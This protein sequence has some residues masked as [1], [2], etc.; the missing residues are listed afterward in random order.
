MAVALGF[1]LTRVIGF[2]AVL[3]TFSLQNEPK[4]CENYFQYMRHLL[5][6]CFI[7]SPNNK[8][9]MRNDAVSPELDGP[10]WIIQI[11]DEGEDRERD[12]YK[13]GIAWE[14]LLNSGYVSRNLME[15]QNNLTINMV[16]GNHSN[17]VLSIQV[18]PVLP[19]T[20]PGER[21]LSNTFQYKYTDIPVVF[22]VRAYDY[23]NIT[24]SLSNSVHQHIPILN[25]GNSC[26]GCVEMWSRLSKSS[27]DFE[28]NYDCLNAYW[29][30]KTE[31]EEN[32]SAGLQCHSL[33]NLLPTMAHRYS[34]CFAPPV[35]DY[36]T[37]STA[38]VIGQ[39]VTLICTATGK[40]TPDIHWYK[41]GQMLTTYSNYYHVPDVQEEHL[42]NYMCVAD[43]MVSRV[44]S[45]NPITISLYDNECALHAEKEM[46]FLTECSQVGEVSEQSGGLPG[47]IVVP[48]DTTV[49]TINIDNTM[50][51][52]PIEEY[53]YTDDGHL[54][55]DYE[56]ST[57]CN[58]DDGKLVSFQL[59]IID[60]TQ[61]YQFARLTSA[62]LNSAVLDSIPTTRSMVGN[63]DSIETTVS[64]ESTFTRFTSERSV[65]RT[66]MQG[67]R[68]SIHPIT[69]QLTL[70]EVHSSE[71]SGIDVESIVSVS[72]QLVTVLLQ[73]ASQHFTTESMETAINR[74]VSKHNVNSGTMAS[75]APEV[76][77]L[78]IP[79]SVI[80]SPEHVI[81]NPTS[82]P[83]ANS[84]NEDVDR[85][86]KKRD[87]DSYPPIPSYEFL[88]SEE[89]YN[90]YIP[91][92]CSSEKVSLRLESGLKIYKGNLLKI[93]LSRL[94][95]G[96]LYDNQCQSCISLEYRQ[97]KTSCNV[98]ENGDC[99]SGYFQWMNSLSRV[100]NHGCSGVTW[101]NDEYQVCHNVLPNASISSSLQ[102][103]ILQHEYT[104]LEC[105]ISGRPVPTIQ[106]FLGMQ[107]GSYHIRCSASNMF[108]TSWSDAVIVT[109]FTE[110]Y[111]PAE[112]FNGF[113]WPETIAGQ[114]A[115]SLERCPADKQ[116]RGQEMAS[117]KCAGNFTIGALWEEVDEQD[118]GKD[119]N[120]NLVLEQLSEVEITDDNVKR[121]ADELCDLTEDF[122][123]LTVDGVS[124][125]AD[126]LVHIVSGT[127][128]SLV[129]NDLLNSV[130][131]LMNVDPAVLGES[132]QSTKS[133]I[134][135]L[136]SLQTYL[137]EVEMSTSENSLQEVATHIGFQVLEDDTSSFS[138][139]VGFVSIADGSSSTNFS[140]KAVTSP[141]DIDENMTDASIRL[142]ASILE[143]SPIN[144]KTRFTFIIFQSAALFQSSISSSSANNDL[145]T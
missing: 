39:S 58:S 22:T 27:C 34:T 17:T 120:I 107:T 47:V 111:C 128:S 89:F 31:S 61:L 49:M 30:W 85:E 112:K 64:T 95:D 53:S 74:D 75:N 6:R 79:V 16:H 62:P 108:G 41:E 115:E 45:S 4:E 126:V 8:L 106:W 78:Q 73:N 21:T 72:G 19:E 46:R 143:D 51:Y 71:E 50:F 54:D 32:E 76:S 124:D 109:V 35:I 24:M 66:G 122:L 9:Y 99:L 91:A 136:Q 138:N 113:T 93:R 42:G 67:E 65:A 144:S 92:E 133:S 69:E 110:A 25:I 116:Y 36:V 18:Q 57:L 131:N 63:Q 125:S 38:V 104:I 134:K 130:N 68:S 132:Q 135:T 2:L 77:D 81:E 59:E 97:F 117:R 86:R 121:V 123:N 129:S 87:D 26:P 114:Q 37:P 145:V 28:S 103:D 83:G 139:G 118:C 33:N 44:N 55:A 56:Y 96:S 82:Q 13:I 105:Q 127:N 10:Q 60:I 90:I 142:P 14:Y 29:I 5:V 43:S 7:N 98:S 52:T 1:K 11:P 100:K 94:D 84:D 140:V 3:I 119:S 40:P 15:E 141:V 23:I 88:L 70:S 137:D 101:Y 12:V 20:Q 48:H 102:N 80:G